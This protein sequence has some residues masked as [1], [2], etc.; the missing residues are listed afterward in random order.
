M[1]RLRLRDENLK[2][3]MPRLAELLVRIAESPIEGLSHFALFHVKHRRYVREAAS[4]IAG[5]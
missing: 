3:M 5:L 4:T 1:L 2:D